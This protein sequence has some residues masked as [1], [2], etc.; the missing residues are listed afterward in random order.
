MGV[1]VVR[2]SDTRFDVVRGESQVLGVF[3]SKAM[4]DLFVEA[5]RSWFGGLTPR[6]PNAEAA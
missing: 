3:A 5:I 2:V 1:R 4:A 6:L